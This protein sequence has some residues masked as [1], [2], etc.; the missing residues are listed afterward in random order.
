MK[1]AQCRMARSGLRWSLDDLAQESGIS[2][3]TI[4][5]FE[6]GGRVN[7]ETIDA[8]RRTLETAGAEFIDHHDTVGVVLREGAAVEHLPKRRKPPP[9]PLP[10]LRASPKVFRENGEGGGLQK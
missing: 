1:I 6:L 10:E 8:L 7:D 5:R 2:R 9:P 3:R 4:A